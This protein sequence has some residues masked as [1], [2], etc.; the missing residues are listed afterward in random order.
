MGN[1]DVEMEDARKHD[2]DSGNN[3]VLDAKIEMKGEK[4][5]STVT[6]AGN[7]KKS[8][9]SGEDLDKLSNE[10]KD[11]ITVKGEIE[12]QTNHGSETNEQMNVEGSTGEQINTKS[13]SEDRNSTKTNAE[14]QTAARST[15]DKL[16]Y[17]ENE[18]VEQNA[19]NGGMKEENSA[20]NG[21]EGGN[22]VKNVVEENPSGDVAVERTTGTEREDG[23][24]VKRVAT[25]EM[26][27]ENAD[28]GSDP[29]ENR[30]LQTE[31][32]SNESPQMQTVTLDEVAHVGDQEMEDAANANEDIAVNDEPKQQGKETLLASTVTDGNTKT[33]ET[34]TKREGDDSSLPNQHEAATPNSLVI[35]SPAKV[36][37]HSGETVKTV[38]TQAALP[39]VIELI[40]ER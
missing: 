31:L 6:A 12:G 10:A 39:L 17:A 15:A 20:E 13:K 30:K 1:N 2:Y 22:P 21:V 18:V 3:K 8:E 11:Q 25:K 23:D 14:E 26:A 38:F 34:A 9:N 7:A 29:R 36:G 28:S 35:Y 33:V 40:P 19:A 4:S 32:S 16:T 37:G 24:C 27:N 5:P